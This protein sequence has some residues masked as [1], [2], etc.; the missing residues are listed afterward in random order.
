[1]KTKSTKR[2]FN[3]EK[4]LKEVS[5]SNKNFRSKFLNEKN[6]CSLNSKMNKININENENKKTFAD[7]TQTNIDVSFDCSLLSI[8]ENFKNI[9]SF[10]LIKNKTM[11]KFSYNW[12][13][14]HSELGISYLYNEYGR[15]GLNIPFNKW[16]I[17][18]NGFQKTLN[19]NELNDFFNGK[20]VI[21]KKLNMIEKKLDNLN[22]NIKMIEESSNTFNKSQN[23]INNLNSSLVGKYVLQ[24]RHLI[25]WHLRD[26]FK[27]ILDKLLFRIELIDLKQN[28]SKIVTE[29]QLF[30]FIKKNDIYISQIFTYFNE[31]KINEN[32]MLIDP[33]EHKPEHKTEDKI[34]D[35]T[36]DKNVYDARNISYGKCKTNSLFIVRPLHLRYEAQACKPFIKDEIDEE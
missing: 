32:N 28:K 1:M 17:K 30:N 19:I 15:N 24:T 31:L 27:I 9:L 16:I 29:T 2:V 20:D 26:F 4:L 8:L 22:V 34:E 21:C 25:M 6:M 11:L 13:F 23:L 3:F 10:S 33:K 5:N 14:S 35:K 36:K 12:S 18:G 7:Y